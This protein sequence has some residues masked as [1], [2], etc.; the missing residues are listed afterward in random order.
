MTQK[1]NENSDHLEPLVPISVEQ[2]HE[3]VQMRDHFSHVIIDVVNNDTFDLSQV[4]PETETLPELYEQLTEL[5]KCLDSFRPFNPSQVQHLREIFDTEYTYESNAIEGNSLTLS[6]T[7]DVLKHGLTIAGKP[8]K[9]HLEA[10][11]H[12]EAIEYLYDL[13]STETPFTERA[14][15][16]LHE[17]I[18]RGI[19]RDNAGRFRRNEV[20]I[21][22]QGGER[23]HF[24]KAR[25]VF[26][27]VEDYLI[28]FEEN[29]N[30]MHPVQLAA[31]MHH[32]L[33]NI[34]PFIDGN[35]RTARLVMNLIL[36]QAGY[37]ITILESE[38]TKRHAYYDALTE[39][40][41]TEDYDSF[42]LLIAEYVKKWCLQYLDILSGDISEHNHDKGHYYFKKISPF[43][44]KNDEFIPAEQ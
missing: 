2:Q 23:H 17:I 3:L 9:D 27:L 13:V 5:K 31:Q 18:L 36:Q 14:L 29:K 41:K 22:E 24:P 7:Q 34:H 26:K 6:E 4:F 8:M 30:T 1:P 25:M 39:F 20:F 44:V 19:D 32:R 40:H 21:I 10:I 38:H 16:N 35:G 33:V 43:L 42:E 28:F 37:P 15:L 12:K 11:N